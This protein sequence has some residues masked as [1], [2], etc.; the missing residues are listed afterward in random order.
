MP[1]REVCSNCGAAVVPEET[2]TA[3]LSLDIINAA[4]QGGRRR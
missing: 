4:A 2:D 3:T 1:P